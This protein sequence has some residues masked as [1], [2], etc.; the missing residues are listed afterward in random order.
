MEK[1]LLKVSRLSVSD[2]MSVCFR[3]NHGED[4][5]MQEVVVNEDEQGTAE[6]AIDTPA[7]NTRSKKGE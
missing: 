4:L 5:E 3:S 7:R 6:T 1:L 2:L